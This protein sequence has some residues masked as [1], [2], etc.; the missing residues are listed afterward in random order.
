MDN[1]I[2]DNQSIVQPVPGSIFLIQME[3]EFIMWHFL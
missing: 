3:K 1:K 2:I